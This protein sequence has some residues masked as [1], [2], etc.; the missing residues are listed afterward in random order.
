MFKGK[1]EGRGESW[2]LLAYIATDE[3]VP[4]TSYKAEM[5]KP[6]IS[7]GLIGGFSPP[8]PANLFP[9]ANAF[10]S[11]TFG[12]GGDLLKGFNIYFIL[13]LKINSKLI[14]INK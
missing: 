11:G 9:I 4:T 13:L 3:E 8:T 5:D 14:I 1:L 12:D 2:Q 6:Q 10:F 7:C